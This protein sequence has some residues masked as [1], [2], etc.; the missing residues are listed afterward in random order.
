MDALTTASGTDWFAFAVLAFGGFAGAYA[1]WYNLLRRYRVDQV[2]PF[3]LL[4]PV[5]GV[6]S[7]WVLLDERPTLISIGGGLII[8]AGL[9]IVVIVPV[10][11]LS[12][13]N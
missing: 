13:K 6:L 4:M 10:A 7:S 3:V 11:A 1:I 9:A 12:R 8:L 5:I 2:A